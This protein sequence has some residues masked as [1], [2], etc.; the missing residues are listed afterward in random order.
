M[1]ILHN[2]CINEIANF[3][4][5]DKKFNL[6]QILFISTSRRKKYEIWSNLLKFRFSCLEIS[7]TL[8][9]NHLEA[10]F[11]CK[12]NSNVDANVVS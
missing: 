11:L 1:K 7:I 10:G 2:F 8:F 5:Q 9:Q 6:K 3:R 12:I 4:W